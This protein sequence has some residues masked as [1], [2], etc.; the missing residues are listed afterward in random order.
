MIHVY[1]DS[2]SSLSLATSY[3]GGIPPFSLAH[4]HG[5]VEVTSRSTGSLRAPQYYAI[6]SMRSLSMCPSI[7]PR[8]IIAPYASSVILFMRDEGCSK[9]FITS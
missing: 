2:L 4:A 8:L 7:D 1:G 6:Q 3:S 9:F 5:M